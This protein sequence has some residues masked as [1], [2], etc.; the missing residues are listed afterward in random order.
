MVAWPGWQDVLAKQGTLP[1]LGLYSPAAQGAQVR[2]VV[3]LAAVAC[4]WPARLNSI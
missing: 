2:S 4:V 3:V 1:A